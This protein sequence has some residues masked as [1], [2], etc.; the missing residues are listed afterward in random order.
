[1]MDKTRKGMAACFKRTICEV[2][3]EIYD[4]LVIELAATRPEVI[5][6]IV[7]L[8]EEAFL[9]GVKL[10]KKLVENKLA[11]QDETGQTNDTRKAIALRRERIRLVKMLEENDEILRRYEEPK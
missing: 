8:L 9:M 11:N 10:N 6:R 2:H 1:M 7:P 4:I 5:E 3:R